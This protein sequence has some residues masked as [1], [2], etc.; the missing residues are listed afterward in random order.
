MMI[1]RNPEDSVHDE[2]FDGKEK[3]SESAEENA[4]MVDAVGQPAAESVTANGEDI[5]ADA[6]PDKEEDVASDAVAE[7]GV[8]EV[9]GGGDLLVELRR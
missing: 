2:L 7:D 9:L 5:P 8:V 6:V 4:E 1:T 3:T